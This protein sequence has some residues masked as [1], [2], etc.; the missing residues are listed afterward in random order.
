MHKI[1]GQNTLNSIS[2][3]LIFSIKVQFAFQINKRT[4]IHRFI[5]QANPLAYMLHRLNFIYRFVF[6]LKIIPRAFRTAR[7]SLQYFLSFKNALFKSEKHEKKAIFVAF[8]LLWP[9][10][11]LLFHILS[12]RMMIAAR[13][14]RSPVSR[15]IFMVFFPSR[16]AFSGGKESSRWVWDV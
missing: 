16:A 3:I 9:A 13:W 8:E 14:D 12:S 1:S 7:L 15:K 6:A 11:D 2:Q 5:T 10:Q 4:R